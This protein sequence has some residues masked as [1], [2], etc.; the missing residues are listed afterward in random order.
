MKTNID[1][2]LNAEKTAFEV[3]IT[4]PDGQVLK[5]EADNVPEA[6]RI[7]HFLIEAFSQEHVGG[8]ERFKQAALDIVDAVI[9]APPVSET[10]H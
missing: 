7:A 4:R 3:S 6:S 5:L 8:L 2:D 1:V 9:L 10:P